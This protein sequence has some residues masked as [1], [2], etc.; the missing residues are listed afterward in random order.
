MLRRPDVSPT[1]G[2]LLLALLL[3]AVVVAP[4]LA[5]GAAET[6]YARKYGHKNYAAR[7]AKYIGRCKGGCGRKGS[8]IRGCIQRDRKTQTSNC[9]QVYQADHALCTDVTCAK[10]VKARLKL[11]LQ[12]VAGQARDDTRA[13]TRRG[14][15]VKRCG[16]CCQKT[17]GGGNCLSYFSSSRFAGAARYHGRLAC[18]TSGGSGA[19]CSRRCERAAARGRAACGKSRDPA[20][21]QQVENVLKACLAACQHA[22]SPSTAFLGGVP[23]RI[24]ARVAGWLPWL[25]RGWSA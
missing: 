1:L 15:G 13:I 20:C 19:D 25:V 17:K 14:Y 9:R 6:V 2:Y 4:L 24:R 5:P 11:C 21:V 16:G 23:A 18:Y 22:G 10:D 7:Y 8:A 3:L 12:N